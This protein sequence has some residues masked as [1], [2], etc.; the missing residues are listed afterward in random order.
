[1]HFGIFALCILQCIVGDVRVY[2]YSLWQIPLLVKIKCPCCFFCQLQGCFLS[3]EMQMYRFSSSI[4]TNFFCCSTFGRISS[5]AMIGP[6]HLSHGCLRT[7]IS[8]TVLV[9]L[10]LSSLSTTLNMGH[11]SLG[12]LWVTRTRLQLLVIH[13]H[14]S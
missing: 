13:I 11:I 4:W 12:K 5:T 6:V 3:L 10:G 14:F 8:S 7:T 2:G 1:M 9:K